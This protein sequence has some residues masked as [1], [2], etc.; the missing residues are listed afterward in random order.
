MPVMLRTIFLSGILI[1]TCT[2]KVSEWVLLNVAPEEYQLVC[3]SGQDQ[4]I[5]SQIKAVEKE[6]GGA[7]VQLKEARN[8]SGNP[9]WFGLYYR[10]RLV[11]KYS[12]QSAMKNIAVSPL[13]EKIAAEIM[14][15]KLCVM[16]F[17]KTDDPS[18]D[19]RR[20]EIIQRKVKESPFREVIT[21][22][23]LSRN[24][25]GE[26]DFVSMLLNV[27]DDLKGIK[28]PMLFGIFG[29]FRALE[30]LV[31]GGITDEN[32]GYMIEFLTAD[33]SCLIKDDLPGADILFSGKWEDPHPALVN[34][35]LDENPSLQH[36]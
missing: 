26:S 21:I 36:R 4:N 11:K 31:A 16:L 28:E 15:G 17:L 18:K 29:R 2:T 32:V 19:D 24:N 33:C 9:D 27:E 30:P 1:L 34:R 20:R 13:R 25:T 8:T 10:N 12:G 6:I 14:A 5:S 35:I 7:N 22:V 3:F 23:E